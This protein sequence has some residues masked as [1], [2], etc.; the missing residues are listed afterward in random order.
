MDLDEAT[1]TTGRAMPQDPLAPTR[2]FA[3]PE[4][5]AKGEPRATVAFKALKAVWFNTGTL[6]NLA[7]HNCYIE[8][9]PRNDRLAYLT[10][11]E[12]RAF[13]EESARLAGAPVEIGFTGGEP[14][15]NP[16]IL[17]MLEDS[18]CAGHRVLVLTNAMKPMRRVGGALL[19]L[20]ERFPAKLTVRVSLDYYG[21]AGHEKI[22]GPNSWLPAIE[23]LRWLTAFGFDVS[24]AA[25]MAWDETEA[26]T[27]A[28]F[29]TLFE[30]L[31][32]GVDA[33]DRGQLVLFPEMDAQEHVPEISENCWRTI[34]K[35][36]DDMMCASSR[37]VL[38]RKGAQT[39]VIA[40]CTL[41]P[42]SQAFE[43]G[44]TLAEST[45]PVRLNHVYCARFCVLGGAS[46]GS[47]KRTAHE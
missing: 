16:D 11:E 43:M 10:R 46:C 42:Y 13:L 20:N 28:G 47:H 1:V 2:K 35:S 9:S 26:E 4:L 40:S 41:L 19:E 33:D 31:G 32:L 21:A 38:K 30:R 18:L 36:P 24:I 5:T 44:S 27:R 39:P 3:D 7:C 23:G 25:R 12:A 8:S 14:F 22:R 45:H 37:M 34:G 17:A 15:M 6:C 29:R